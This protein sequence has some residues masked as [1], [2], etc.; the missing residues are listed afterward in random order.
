MLSRFHLLSKEAKRDDLLG[1]CT[2]EAKVRLAKG[3]ALVNV[4]LMIAFKM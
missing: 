3:K 2:Y 4:L 1:I